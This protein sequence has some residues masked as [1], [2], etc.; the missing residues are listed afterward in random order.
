MACPGGCIGGGGQ[1]L[2]VNNTKL[3]ARTNALYRDDAEVQLLRQSHENPAVSD[4][5]RT[6]LKEPN[7]ETAHHYLHTGYTPRRDKELEPLEKGKE[8]WVPIR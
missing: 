4:A 5:Y 6:F 8:S 1:P 7:S 2:P 3:R